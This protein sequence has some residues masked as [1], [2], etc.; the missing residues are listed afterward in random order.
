MP[1][2]TT[3]SLPVLIE[4]GADDLYS[5]QGLFLYQLPIFTTL[6]LPVLNQTIWSWRDMPALTTVTAPQLSYVRSSFAIS[7]TPL[8]T[9]VDFLGNVRLFDNG[10]TWTKPSTSNSS[11][12]SVTGL[13]GLKT[14]LAGGIS[15]D[16]APQF[17]CAA[18]AAPTNGIQGVRSITFGGCN[19]ASTCAIATPSPQCDVSHAGPNILSSFSFTCSSLDVICCNIIIVFNVIVSMWFLHL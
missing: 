16:V 17:C 11:L 10:I 2:F 14:N 1:S 13:C 9:N 15:I 4:A 6:T 7:N 18:G 8:L 12:I 3:L 19:N 5:T